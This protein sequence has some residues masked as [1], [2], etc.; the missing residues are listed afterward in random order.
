M[1]PAPNIRRD[2]F[3]Y[4][5]N[6]AALAAGATTESAI[7]I[8][9]DSEFET[10]KLS[11]FADIAAAA[12]TSSTRVLPL[13]T[14]Q[15]TDT[16]TGRQM[17]NLPVPIPAIMGDGQ[18]PFILPTTKTFQPS[19]AVLISVANYSAATAYNLR[20]LLIGAKIFNYGGG[21]A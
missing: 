15:I 12:Q 1:K 4:A 10:Q 17:F 7:Q 13:V 18:I 20:L 6:F 11:M 16:G 8:Q 14:L 2:F 3:V 9:A 21:N 19:S 5:I